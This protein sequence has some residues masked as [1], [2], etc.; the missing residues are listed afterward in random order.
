MLTVLLASLF[1]ASAGQAAQINGIADENLEQWGPASWSAF[2]ATGVT[3]VRHIVP[4]TLMLSG[5]ENELAEATAW[6]N[7]A[8]SRGLEVLISFGPSGTNG[9]PSAS[10]LLTQM[11]AF[12]ARFPNIGY[13]TPFNEPNH[14]PSSW[15]DSAPWN[16]PTVAADYWHLANQACHDASLGPA[17]TVI[18]GDFS[19]E[20]TVAGLQSY[21]TA[22]K[23]RLS[24]AYGE[25]PAIWAI[26]PYKAVRNNDPALI[27]DGFASQIGT[28]PYWFTEVGGLVCNPGSGWTGGGSPTTLAAA[29]EYQN[30]YAS[31]LLS[32]MNNQGSRL[33][34]T[35]YYALSAPNDTQ[36]SCSTTGG[37]WDSN[38]LG[39]GGSDRPA[40]H[41]L[42]PAAA[43][44]PPAAPT[45]DTAAASSVRNVDAVLNGTL[46][47]NGSDTSYHFEYGLTPAYGGRLPAT[48][49]AAPASGGAISPSLRAGG[50]VP[51]A[52]YHYRLVASSAGGGANGPD[53]TF[54]TPPAIF[55]PDA[56][57]SNTVS[58]WTFGS[59]AGWQQTFLFGH[60]VAAG[61]SPA[62]M[63]VDGLPHM[64]FVD[65]ARG[66]QI[67]EWVWDSVAGWEQNF[68]ATDPVAANTS[69]TT[70]IVSGTPHVFFVDAATGRTITALSKTT[71]GWQQAKL[72]GHPVS[73]GSSP[74]AVTAG[75]VT[76]VF[77]PDQTNANTV[78]DWTW[79]SS[80]GWQQTFLWG[81]PVAANSSP[82]AVAWGDGTPRAY[83]VDA[84]NGNTI[85]AWSWN[86]SA[87]WQQG[88]RNG[89]AV[90]AGSSPAAVP[91]GDAIQV[92]FP[93][94]AASNTISAWTWNATTGWELAQLFGHAV[95]AGSSP[96]AEIIG[97]DIDVF[98][99][100]A[101]DGG[102]MSVW[103]WNTSIQQTL[104]WGHPLVSGTSPS[105]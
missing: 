104:L 65:A 60:A 54:T 17:C 55:F 1:F 90:G 73:A 103:T 81:H 87:G 32:L 9:R 11:R 53:K 88:F 72:F 78:T 79:N 39:A 5:H 85:T 74:S 2:G 40:F 41:T 89:H 37:V 59:T 8:Q 95:A 97:S 93:D 61:S 14:G 30:G 45:A 99:A 101:V 71:T 16:E 51:G 77:F 100:D 3:K 105:R 43:Y 76:H 33:Q 50:L 66:N 27:S 56:T 15:P 13:Y 36:A 83:F 7:A 22:Y 92:F 44:P 48:D 62:Q 31:T 35:Y 20:T 86:A 82:S 84:T 19:D 25:S 70:A 91:V 6:I 10:F 68:I 67:T 64:F 26:H 21:V 63:T 57:N 102:T 12:R 24:S 98:F 34:R 42:F 4:W 23:N 47:P 29:V 58:Y 49:A 52:T 18:A 80:T 38:L 94:A 75:G 28:K 69:P 46:N 96:S